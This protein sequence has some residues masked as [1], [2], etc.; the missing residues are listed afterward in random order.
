MATS[1]CYMAANWMSCC[2]AI[3]YS[4][5]DCSTLRTL[6]RDRPILLHL[7]NGMKKVGGPEQCG[8]NV[9]RSVLAR[10]NNWTILVNEVVK[11]EVPWFEAF[12]SMATLLQLDGRP[13]QFERA[14]SNMGSLLSIPAVTLLRISVLLN[15]M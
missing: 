6:L 1:C 14:A 7:G 13:P 15:Y 5:L 11:A 12:S 2:H 9:L 3:I 10:M 4:F 8:Q